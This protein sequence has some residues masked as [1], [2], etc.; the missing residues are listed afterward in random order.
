M[1]SQNQQQLPASQQTV[2]VQQAPSNNLGLA[3]FI[4]SLV[5]LLS[6]GLL[7]PISLI[8]S[9]IGLFKRPRGFAIAGTIISGLE[10]LAIILIG[11]API[12]AIVGIGAAAHAEKKEEF[13]TNKVEIIETLR[14]TDDY[15]EINQ[16]AVDYILIE[17]KEFKK[18]LKEARE[19]VP[20]PTP[21]EIE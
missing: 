21:I 10:L 16:L 14:S 9:F 12:L 3:G 17:D 11:L 20:D 15:Q 7:S 5:S 8:L 4:T 18:A 19:R 13:E 6:C 1:D 2:V